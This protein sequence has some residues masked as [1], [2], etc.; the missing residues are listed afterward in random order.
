MSNQDIP[1]YQRLLAAADAIGEVG[2]APSGQLQPAL[3][4]ALECVLAALDLPES[5]IYLYSP[6]MH[7]LALAAIFPSNGM[8]ANQGAQLW[9]AKDQKFLPVLAALTRTA[10]E[11]A[12]GDWLLGIGIQTDPQSPVPNPQPPVPSPQSLALPLLAGAATRRDP[13]GWPELERAA[14]RPAKRAR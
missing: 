6:Q 5:G 2:R 11:G 14:T 10:A 12:I 7:N 8:I 9:L 4:Q 13:S 1:A 3:E